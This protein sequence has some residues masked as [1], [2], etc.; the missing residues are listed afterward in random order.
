MSVWTRY[1]DLPHRIKSFD[2]LALGDTWA[3]VI[4]DKVLA[5]VNLRRE[6]GEYVLTLR[7]PKGAWSGRYSNLKHAVGHAHD[8]MRENTFED[9]VELA[10]LA[11]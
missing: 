9:E 8:Y 5:Q 11:A 1:H 7:E 3:V 2:S 6:H 4:D 10:A